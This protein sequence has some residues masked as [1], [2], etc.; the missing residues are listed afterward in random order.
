MGDRTCTS[1]TN[2]PN[3]IGAGHILIIIPFGG[4]EDPLSGRSVKSALRL[5][6]SDFACREVISMRSSSNLT[7]VGNAAAS[8]V[9]SSVRNRSQG[10]LINV[11]VWIKWTRLRAGIYSC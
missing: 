2:N 6:F 11:L 1:Y 5:G 4:L 9:G 3:L 7:G 8:R 10:Q